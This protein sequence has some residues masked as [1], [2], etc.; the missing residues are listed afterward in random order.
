MDVNQLNQ[1]QQQQQQAPQAPGQMTMPAPNFSQPTVS[2][3]P[4][5]AQAVAPQVNQQYLQ[6][7]PQ[8]N[9][10]PGFPGNLQPGQTQP[11]V[12]EQPPQLQSPLPFQNGQIA[13]QQQAPVQQP[14]PPQQQQ[15]VQQPQQTPQQPQQPQQ[16]LNN[17]EVNTQGYENVD[18]DILQS[19]VDDAYS[20]GLSP[21]QARQ[22]IDNAAQEGEFAF[23]SQEHRA[24]YGDAMDQLVDSL[25]R[26][27]GQGRSQEML[28]TIINNV[29]A[30]GGDAL[31]EKF[32]S[33]PDMLH[34]E[35]VAG[36]L[37]GGAQGPQAGNPYD[38]HIRQTPAPG[39]LAPNPQHQQQ[40][41]YT[42][43]Q[44]QAKI[45][46]LMRKGAA[47]TPEENQELF[48]LTLAKNEAIH[49]GAG[50]NFQNMY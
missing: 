8:S 24:A 10:A 11:V 29:H 17:Y 32:N 13:P 19:L 43:Q 47:I 16:D 45:A 26:E 39:N 5:Q 2:F 41:Q 12:V 9:I 31:V 36:Y 4:G 22:Y 35:I 7:H 20:Q 27:Y 50:L 33:D 46:E 25:E 40:G 34:P 49:Q 15:V 6:P 37:N 21:E 14:A 28:Q 3:H 38:E 23:E 44:A 42:P 1:Q 48:R 30:T 18:P